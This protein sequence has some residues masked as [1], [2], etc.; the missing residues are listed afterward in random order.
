MCVCV[1]VC[2]RERER[3]REREQVCMLL[4]SPQ[5]MKMHAQTMK[6]G[7]QSDARPAFVNSRNTNFSS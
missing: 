4:N 6:A 2:V 3:E 7:S 1:C 5:Y